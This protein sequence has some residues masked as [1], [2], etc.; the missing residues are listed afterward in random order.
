MPSWLLST[1]TSSAPAWPCLSPWYLTALDGRVARLTNTETLFGKEY[2]SLADMVSFGLAPAIVSYQWGVARIAE[3]G[4]PGA[5]LAGWRHFST[6]PARRCAWPASIPAAATQ[7]KSYFE[8]L[9]VRRPPP[10]SRPSSG[11]RANGASRGCRPD[12]RLRGHGAGRRA[13]GQPLRISELQDRSTSIAPI[14]FFWLV[15]LV[16]VIVIVARRPAPHI[17]GQLWSAMR[18]GHRSC[19]SGGGC[20]A[21]FAPGRAAPGPAAVNRRAQY[22][23]GA[24]H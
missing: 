21:R 12:T 6:R 2:D 8:G 22:L 5:D 18:S 11:G 13:D 23:R 15:L 4:R 1:G 17:A 14:R 16:V 24:R 10:W 20:A 3:Y 19:G 9:P 7:N